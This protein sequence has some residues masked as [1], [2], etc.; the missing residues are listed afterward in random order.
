MLKTSGVV[1]QTLYIHTHFTVF[2]QRFVS[3]WKCF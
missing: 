3:F 1:V 2:R